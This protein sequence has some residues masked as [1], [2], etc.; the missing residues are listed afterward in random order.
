MNKPTM[1]VYVSDSEFVPT[2]VLEK[3]TSMEGFRASTNEQ[4]YEFLIHTVGISYP[5]Q[6]G[7][8]HIDFECMLDHITDLDIEQL[9]H[10]EVRTVYVEDT[11]N[12]YHIHPFIY[13]APNSE[14]HVKYVEKEQ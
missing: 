14:I 12:H 13:H 4:R 2:E 8:S 7:D 11:A 3:V 5:E 9:A 1:T 6:I 10:E